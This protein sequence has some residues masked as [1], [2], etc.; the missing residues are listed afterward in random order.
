MIPCAHHLL[1]PNKTKNEQHPFK[2][3]RVDEYI[4]FSK[5]T[6]ITKFLVDDSN[7]S[8]EIICV[9]A[10]WING[11]N[12]RHNIIINNMVISGL[13]DINQY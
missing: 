4:S 5:S 8:M 7:I 6:N 2:L 11:N 1:R 3:V 10:S 9:D 12:E 13:L